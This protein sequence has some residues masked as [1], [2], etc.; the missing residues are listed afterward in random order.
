MPPPN[1]GPW[2]DSWL[3]F[4]CA[5]GDTELGVSVC[6]GSNFGTQK[7]VIGHLKKDG[8]DSADDVPISRL[9]EHLGT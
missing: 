5:W 2:G 4:G 9:L 7:V 8:G 3:S 1:A 6:T